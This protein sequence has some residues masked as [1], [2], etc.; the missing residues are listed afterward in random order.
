MSLLTRLAWRSLRHRPWQALLLL[1]V[2]AVSSTALA[3]ALG[4]TET[5]DGA[6]DRMFDATRAAHVT[7][8]ANYPEDMSPPDRERLRSELF[9]AQAS[10][11]G[12]V[13]AGGPWPL[14]STTEGE[15]GGVRME[16]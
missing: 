16:L 15:V 11:P 9:A 4:V 7:L 13:A 10:A 12:V 3:L 14:L 6:W 5:A 2:L 8:K 1:A